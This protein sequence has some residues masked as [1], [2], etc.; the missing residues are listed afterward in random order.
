MADRS[1]TPLRIA[2]IGDFSG[3]ANRNLRTPSKPIQ[4]DPE[5]FEDVMQRLGVALDFPGAA[6]VRFRE[7]DDFHPDQLYA[8]LPLFDAI[9][10]AKKELANPRNLQAPPAKP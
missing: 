1:D 6:S 7:L 8:H 2:L 5:N 4:I 10:E 9:R 3:R